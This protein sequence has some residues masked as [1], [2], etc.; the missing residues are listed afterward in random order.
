VEFLISSYVTWPR[1]RAKKEAGLKAPRPS[2]FI[3][4]EL[5]WV[6]R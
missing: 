4:S 5:Y 3:K 6:G 2:L 1:H